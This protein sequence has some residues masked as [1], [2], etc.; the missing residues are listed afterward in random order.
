MTR[1]DHIEL[2][3]E[4]EDPGVA[5]I[6]KLTQ[7]LEPR[8]FEL[9]AI[10]APRSYNKRMPWMWRF[11]RR[12]PSYGKIGIF[13]HSW[14]GKVLVERVDDLTPE[15]DLPLIY[16]NPLFSYLAVFRAY[17]YEGVM[18]PAWNLAYMVLSAVIALALGVWVFS[19]SW[20]SLVVVL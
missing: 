1:I 17:V 14:Y 16:S 4:G 5:L 20:K 19:R 18:P 2:G 9:Y 15:E 7:R 3:V 8:G 12:L 10:R 11:W 6:S 13:D